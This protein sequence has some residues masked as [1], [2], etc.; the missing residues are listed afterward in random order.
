MGVRRVV[1]N[2]FDADPEATRDFY[3]GVFEL[4]VAMDLGWIATLAAPGNRSAQLSVFATGAE[5][6]RDPFVSVEVDDVDAVHAR[7][8][9]LGHEV[10]YPL[11][12]EDWGVR[13]FMLRDPTGRVV[14]V[15]SHAEDRPA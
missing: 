5:D 10:V 6:G 3:T 12:D 14:N 11:R 7:A 13:R 1:P 2:L 15:L 8:I 4:E 9:A